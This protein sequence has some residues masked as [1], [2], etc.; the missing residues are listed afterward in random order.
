LIPYFPLSGLDDNVFESAKAIGLEKY[1]SK[2]KKLGNSKFSKSR[3]SPKK[4]GKIINESIMSKKTVLISVG[5]NNIH[6]IL[7][8]VRSDH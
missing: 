4:I 3:Q 7:D 8:E 2:I 6:E 5:P 1:L